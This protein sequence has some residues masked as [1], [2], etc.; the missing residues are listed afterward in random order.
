MGYKTPGKYPCKRCVSM[1]RDSGGNNFHFYGEGLGGYCFSCGHT[2][3]SEQWLSENGKQ[4]EWEED[5]VATREKL[6]P[7][8]VEKIKGYTSTTGKGMR[9]ISDETYKAYGVRHKCSEE[10]GEPVAAYYPVTEEYAGS[11]FKVREYPKTF[12][13]V[14]KCGKESDLFGQWK[15]KTASGKFCVITAGEVDCLSEIGRAHV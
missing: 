12:S 11:G 8:Q 5:E 4:W 9:G 15:F 10:T 6:T 14:G 1:G 3:P 2:T 7:E 13:V